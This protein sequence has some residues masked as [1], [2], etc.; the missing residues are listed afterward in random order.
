MH[1]TIGRSPTALQGQASDATIEAGKQVKLR[2]TGRTLS[3]NGQRWTEFLIEHDTAR[4]WRVLASF[5]TP[6]GAFLAEGP[7]DEV[8][9]VTG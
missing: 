2:V 7:E 6:V 5:K 9:I 4:G 1:R 8:E 3:K